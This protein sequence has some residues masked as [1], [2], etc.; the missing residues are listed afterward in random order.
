M[1][2]RLLSAIVFGLAFAAAYAQDAPAAAPGDSQPPS[3]APAQPSEAGGPQSE[4]PQGGRGG[5][6]MSAGPGLRGTVTGVAADHYTIKTSAGGLYTVYFSAST[7]I[8][9][10]TVWRGDPGEDNGSG[11][12]ARPGPQT[13]Q[14]ADIQA[15]DMV[16]VLG[17]VDHA[18]QSVN[19]RLVLE[20][21][22]ERARQMFA[23][24]ASYGK[25]WLMGQV[26]AVHDTTVTL[27][28]AL[29][30]APHSFVTDENTRFRKRR[31]PITL[32]DLQVGD[33]VHVEG[34]LKDGAFVAARVSVMILP[35]G[36]TPAVPRQVPPPPADRPE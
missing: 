36:G 24:E 35:R 9:K 13:L 30:H 19:A 14:S 33:R 1:K 28:G 22:P 34:A 5:W 20:L 17:D 10:Q 16:A 12:R 11:D 26:T 3:A 18:D 21:D 25:T 7:R 31:Q 32:A 27:L 8:L 15:G 23:L 4:A 2:L 29:D 6:G